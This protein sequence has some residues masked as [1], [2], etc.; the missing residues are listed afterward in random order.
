MFEGEV[1]IRTQSSTLLQIICELMLYL[2]VIFKSM[3]EADTIFQGNSECEWV[4]V[5]YSSSLF[6]YDYVSSPRPEARRILSA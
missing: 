4:K 6:R 5:T 3:K 1:L 2:Q